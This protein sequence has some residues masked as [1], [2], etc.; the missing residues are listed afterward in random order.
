MRPAAGT[1]SGG[2]QLKNSACCL[3]ILE[4]IENSRKINYCQKRT[5]L[6]GSH[7]LKS[8]A[9]K[10]AASIILPYHAA[11]CKPPLP[12]WLP[13][14]RPGRRRPPA[15][16]SCPGGSATPGR[17]GRRGRRWRKR[18][19]PPAPAGPVQGTQGRVK[20]ELEVCGPAQPWRRSSISLEAASS[21]APPPP[22]PAQPGSQAQPLSARSA[23]A[24]RWRAQRGRRHTQHPT[25]PR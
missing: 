2:R 17:R 7:T 25:V 3:L 8:T 13:P 4:C 19:S 14:G 23:H 9:R 24:H 18:W 10:R 11:D 15:Q 22:P 20:H 16:A 12:P 1:G 5:N 21:Q 6:Q